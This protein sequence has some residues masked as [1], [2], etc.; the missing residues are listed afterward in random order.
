MEAQD[1]KP[2]ILSAKSCLDSNLLAFCE[3]KKSKK[4]VQPTK[5]LSESH[6]PLLDDFV[7]HLATWTCP[8]V[9]SLGYGARYRLLV[10]SGS[11]E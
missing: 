2:E 10:A 8:S 1:S 6:L 9:M 4:V 3:S 11:G 7:Y 5:K